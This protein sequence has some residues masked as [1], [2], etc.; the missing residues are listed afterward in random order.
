MAFYNRKPLRLKNFDY[1]QNNAYF[2]TICTQNKKHILGMITD[3]KMILNC[4]GE[5]VKS[6][7]LNIEKW[8]CQYLYR[9]KNH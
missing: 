6:R 3:G 8:T 7:I 2:L 4:F 5:K 9:R 1:S